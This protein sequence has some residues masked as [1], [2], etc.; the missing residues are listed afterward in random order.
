MI[1]TK[2]AYHIALFEAATTQERGHH[3]GVVVLDEPRQQETDPRSLA[4]FLNRLNGDSE[5]GQVL[6]A[7]SQDAVMFAQLLRDI[8]HNSLP[9]SGQNLFV[10]MNG[11]QS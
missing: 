6:Y 8:P 9:A 5:L 1:R 4:A 10:L 11:D 3:L 2:W 7:T